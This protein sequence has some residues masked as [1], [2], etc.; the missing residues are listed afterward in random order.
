MVTSARLSRAE[1]TWRLYDPIIRKWA[2]FCNRSG[3]NPLGG[4]PLVAAAFLTEVRLDVERRMIGPQA[5]ER[6]NAALSAFQGDG[7]GAH[8]L[9]LQTSVP[10]SGKWH[11]GLSHR[12]NAAPMWQLRTRYPSWWSTTSVKGWISLPGWW[13]PAQF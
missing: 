4:D 12:H 9:V 11:D 2:E 10:A 6:A 3:S 13:S 7:Q 1:S 5:V 8:R